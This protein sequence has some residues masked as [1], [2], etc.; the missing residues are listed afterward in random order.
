MP[1]TVTDDCRRIADSGAI[2]PYFGDCGGCQTQDQPYEAQVAGKAAMVGEL[3]SEY[4]TEPVEVTPSPI[5]WHYRNKVDPGFAPK[6]YDTPPPP[7]FVRDT[8]LG[9]KKKG[10]WFWPLDVEE[11]RIAT[12]G[13]GALLASV[14]SWYREKDYRA[15]DSRS[16]EGFL[17]C[18][19]VRD[20]KRTKE[21]MVALITSPGDFDVDSFVSA[22]QRVFP[23]TSI[24][25]GIFEGQAEGS[26]MERTELLHGAAAITEELHLETTSGV[27]P[28]RF[29]ISPMSFFQ[30]NPLA[31]E[32]LYAHIRE[33]VETLK[34]RVLY[35]LYGG[36]GGIAFSCANLVEQ[37]WSVENVP[38]ASEDGRHNALV[39]GIENVEFITANVKDYLRHRIEGGGWEP[40]CAVVLDPPRAGLHPKALRRLME[41]APPS[42]LYVSCAP[43][44]FARE[45]PAFLEDY[46]LTSLRAVDLFPH[47]R[48][49]EVV[50]SFD[51]KR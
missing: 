40:D 44:N 5:V 33:W 12:E 50:A 9:F 23:A 26:M 45:M 18:L 21:R 28:L 17:R 36:A 1:D 42:I 48:H 11:C 2:C 27:L 20:T 15:F 6:R 8:S 47:T 43:K 13:F 31:T 19:L 32:R 37:V 46:R 41:L 35:D 16:G 38:E 29:R 39:N 3:F 7:G 22:V 30:T 4:W 14:R 49:V 51:R 24:Y 25:R 34:V 10:R